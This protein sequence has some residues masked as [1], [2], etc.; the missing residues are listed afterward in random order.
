MIK[1][2]IVD[3][4]VD[5]AQ[6]PRAKAATDEAA[7][8]AAGDYGTLG[9]S[10]RDLG[11]MA[12]RTGKRARA[13]TG[14]DR[15]G[16]SLVSV[17]VELAASRL[18]QGGNGG[19]A[20]GYGGRESPVRETSPSVRGGIPGG[21]PPGATQLLTGRAVLIVGAGSM[22][23]LAVATAATPTNNATPRTTAAHDTTPGPDT[24]PVPIGSVSGNGSSNPGDAGTAGQTRQ[25]SLVLIGDS[26]HEDD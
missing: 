24:T 19:A 22:S 14:I 17:G 25:G 21:R 6:I 4:V 9:R 15:L 12:L 23:G 11:R 7:L 3:L 5:L 10:L 18:G 2:D 20:G 8:K 26:R 1:A 13:E 16:I